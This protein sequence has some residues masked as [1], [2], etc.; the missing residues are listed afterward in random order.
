MA[1]GEVNTEPPHHQRSKRRHSQPKKLVEVLFKIS[2]QMLKGQERHRARVMV[3]EAVSQSHCVKLVNEQL[4]FDQPPK[5]LAVETP[6]DT[7]RT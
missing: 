2:T 3:G 7:L 6:E 5:I 4:H 1:A